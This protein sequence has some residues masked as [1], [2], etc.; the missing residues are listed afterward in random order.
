[1]GIVTGRVRLSHS[2]SVRGEVL[3]TSHDVRIS[4][5][6]ARLMFPGPPMA[7][8][9]SAL[10]PPEVPEPRPAAFGRLLA[11]RHGWGAAAHHS[12]DLDASYSQVDCV[13][14][15]FNVP[16]DEDFDPRA[17]ETDLTAWIGRLDS[18]RAAIKRSAISP[19]YRVTRDSAELIDEH[20]PIGG[21]SIVTR[22][23]GLGGGSLTLTEVSTALRL[24]SEGVDLSQEHALLLDC[25]EALH[26]LDNRKA[27]IDATTAIE[28]ALASQ[29]TEE[30]E[31]AGLPTGF[32]S[33]VTYV[34]NGI[35]GLARLYG[36]LGHD[37][38]VSKGKIGNEVAEV[39]NRASHAGHSPTREE[40]L[41]A[42]GHATKLVEAV[43]GGATDKTSVGGLAEP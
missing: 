23:V 20:G 19:G 14:I 40:A 4:D 3:G 31:A 11:D 30:I 12:A 21:V 39:R 8:G 13:L 17:F 41:R 9:G 33:A 29:I 10:T 18:W 24:A 32:A 16:D 43:R 42:L 2:L 34:A 25:R 27:V 35:V 37:L 28:V 7:D 22:L 36:A 26:E 38:P 6:P 15:Q 5:R 1:M